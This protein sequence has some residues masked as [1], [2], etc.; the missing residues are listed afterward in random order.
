MNNWWELYHKEDNGV[1]IP[2][3]VA[4]KFNVSIE[5]VIE[6]MRKGYWEKGY[7]KMGNIDA[8]RYD[9]EHME[10]FNSCIDI[11]LRRRQ[12]K[13]SFNELLEEDL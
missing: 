2:I 1:W 13:Q 4:R 3:Y 12:F 5:E 7:P 9:K 8:R 10:A 6:V 11:W